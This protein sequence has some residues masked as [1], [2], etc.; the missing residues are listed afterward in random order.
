M[1]MV[2]L[3]G[4][5]A[6]GSIYYLFGDRIKFTGAGA[7]VAAI[8]LIVTMFS[9][10]LAETSFAICGGYVIFWLAL[11]MRVL[12]VSRVAN[13]TDISYGLYLYAWPIQS[14][15]VWSNKAAGS[16]TAVNPWIV[17]FLSVLAASVAAYASWTLVESPCL[18]FA[19][20]NSPPRPTPS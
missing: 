14:L 11:K 12:G 17:S 20:R 19:S 4:V 9:S 10:T 6:V 2:R 3:G 8:L 1:Y 15:I 7:V 18:D 5:Y 13:R 16:H